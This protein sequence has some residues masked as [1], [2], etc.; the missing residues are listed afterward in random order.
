MAVRPLL[1]LDIRDVLGDTTQT[2]WVPARVDTDGTV[3]M[4]GH[5]LHFSCECQPRLERVDQTPVFYHRR[6]V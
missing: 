3:E 5:V 1:Q 6:D 2:H 4:Y